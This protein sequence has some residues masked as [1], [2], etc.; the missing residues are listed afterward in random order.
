MSKSKYKFLSLCPKLVFKY[1]SLQPPYTKTFT[2][3]TFLPSPYQIVSNI[4]M[5]EIVH[6]GNKGVNLPHIISSCL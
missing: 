6:F 1:L 2:K 5:E 4:A 3:D